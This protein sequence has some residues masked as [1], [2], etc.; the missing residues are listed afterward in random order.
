ME[1]LANRPLVRVK[2]NGQGPFAFL[3]APEAS[4]ALIDPRLASELKLKAESGGSSPPQFELQ[5]EV[6]TSRVTVK[7]IAG[8]MATAVPEF[9]PPARPRGVLNAS[10][11][12]SHLV[13][14]DY[15]RSQVAVEPG[16]LP[17]PNR[18][19]VFSLKSDAS[20]LGVTVSIASVVI[21][22]RL[23]PL[24]PGGIFLRE[25]YASSLPLA[26]K[27]VEMGT[28]T[29]AKGRDIVREGEVNADASLGMF[30]LARPLVQFAE[31]AQ[32]CTIGGQRLI[33]FSITYDM[34]NG[35]VRLARPRPR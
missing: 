1:L 18:R 9:A 7:A 11:W 5:L 13:T 16:S 2:V 3:V 19:D 12:P 14:L 15:P 21:A 10:V 31:S 25:T 20:E 27:R 4:A 29:T 26:G 34:A 33:A 24:F 17:D 28:V 35:R 6:G 23:D 30:V 22:C 32:G 8:D